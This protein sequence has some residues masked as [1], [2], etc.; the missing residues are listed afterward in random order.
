MTADNFPATYY[1]VERI[2]AYYYGNGSRLSLLFLSLVEKL[3]CVF[4]TNYQTYIAM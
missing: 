3:L 1:N 4:S 2:R